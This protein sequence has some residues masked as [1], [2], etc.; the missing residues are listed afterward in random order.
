MQAMLIPGPPLGPEMVSASPEAVLAALERFDPDVPWR[1]A[2][3]LV[4]PMLPRQ[5]P[6]PFT[7]DDRVTVTLS[8]GLEVGFGLDLGPAMVFVGERQLAGWGIDR[9]TLVAAALENVR[10]LAQGLPPGLV[11][12]STMGDVPVQII[13][14]GEGIASALLLVPDTLPGLIGNGPH[15]L[16][17]PMRDVLIALP[18][19]ADP[20]FAAWLADE[21]ESLDPNSLHLGLFRHEGGTVA[22]EPPGREAVR[23]PS[24]GNMMH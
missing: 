7:V 11:V 22:R 10:R 6:Y 16:A 12:G 1:A 4:L 24:V 13:Q 21:M 17:A 5:R 14:T 19:T 15:L 20:A 8:A 3:S 23:R 2:G 18:S 9:A